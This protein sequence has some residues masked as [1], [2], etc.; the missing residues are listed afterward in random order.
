MRKWC[1]SRWRN[2][3][4]WFPEANESWSSFIFRWYCFLRE[5]GPLLGGKKA[6]NLM[7]QRAFTQPVGARMKQ[8][9][10]YMWELP[11]DPKTSDE[12]MLP[13]N[14]GKISEVVPWAEMLYA[15]MVNVVHHRPFSNMR[16]RRSYV[17]LLRSSAAIG[18]KRCGP[19]RSALWAAKAARR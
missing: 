13:K 4:C 19:A 8:R 5:F 11:Q 9:I 10:D 1:D 16:V 14:V 6:T 2:F 15:I 17:A 12:P 18:T 3:G 7:I